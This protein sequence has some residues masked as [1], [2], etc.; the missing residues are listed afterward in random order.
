MKPTLVLLPGFDGSGR[1]FTPLHKELYDVNTI[2]LS[3]PSDKVMTYSD[4]CHYLKDELPNSPYVLLGESFGGPLAMMLS[5]YADENL[6]GIILCVSFVKNP[7]V[8]LS[9]LIRP[10][11]KPKHLQKETPAW[12]IRTMLMNGVSDTTL[13]RNIQAA[14]AELTRE[15]YFYRL[16][17][18]ADVDVADIL[19]KCELPILYLRAKKDRLVYESSMKLVE[20][21]GKNV[22]VE[23]FDAPHMLL[24]TMPA[25]T[26]QCIKIFMSL[27]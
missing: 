14:T 17:E 15:V 23:T 6:K 8:L 3:Y 22:T 12:H 1:L 25:Q 11:L 10:F 2:V 9:R 16:R 7:Q 24:Q 13:I 20:K 4:L 19:Q 5:K 18:I 21:L 26:A 27:L